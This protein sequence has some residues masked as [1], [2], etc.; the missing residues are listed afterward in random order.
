M[1]RYWLRITLGA[2]GIFVLGMLVVSAGRRGVERVKQLASQH[3]LRLTP[4][5]APF[6]VDLRRLG[7]LTNVEVDHD[8]GKDFPSINLTVQLDPAIESADLGGCTLLA[9]DAESLSDVNGLHCA[10]GVSRDSLIEMGA[11]TFEP[12][13]ERESLYIPASEVGNNPWFN[14]VSR[15]GSLPPSEGSFNLQA[16]AAGAFM[17]IKDDKGRP[18]FQLNADSQGAFIQI[19]DSNG[20]EIVR[21]RADSQGVVGRVHPD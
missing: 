7:T 19:R 3:S 5:V 11:V 10:E 17:L 9:S 18:V 4:G 21:F 13:G 6:L 1:K 2:L 14:R 16:N 20:K 12:S 8:N 15:S